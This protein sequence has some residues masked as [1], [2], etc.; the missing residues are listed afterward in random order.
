MT[1]IGQTALGTGN[2]VSKLREALKQID[3]GV[4]LDEVRRDLD[5]I[6]DAAE[7]VEKDVEGLADKFKS[8]ANSASA[9]VMAFGVGA[10]VAAVQ[11]DN[12]VGQIQA[13]L[14]ATREEAEALEQQAR[15]VWK[16]GFGESLEEV[17]EGLIRVKQNM[18][19]IDG[20]EIE[21]VTKNA[22]S[23][24]KAFESDVNEVTRAANNLMVNFGVSAEEAFDLLAYGAQTGLNFSNELFDNVAEYSGLFKTLGFT[25]EEYFQTLEKGSKQGVYNL[26]YLNDVVKEFG[27][28]IKDGS[29]ST[30]DALRYLF[31]SPEFDTF[32]DNLEKGGKKS[33]EFMELVAKF[34]KE[35]SD[36]L[37]ADLQKGGKAAIEAYEYLEYQFG[38]SGLLLQGISDGSLRGQ[39]AMQQV[40]D[41]VFEIDDASV[42]AQMGVAMFG[43]KW[44]DLEE[45]A[46]SALTGID[47][48]LEN[49]E[50]R[51]KELT[52]VQEQ[53]F[54]QQWGAFTRS[55]AASLEPIGKILLNLAEDWMPKVINVVETGANWFA[56]L[57]PVMQGTTVA[58]GGV[59]AALGPL[60]MVGGSLVST[61]TS[62]V[63]LFS[64]GGV[65]AGAFGTAL[66]VLSGPVG[67]A[68]IGIATVGTAA[69]VTSKQL[70]ESSI[71]IQ[72]WSEGV[73]EATATA[74]GS[75][76]EISDSVSQTLT[77]L[78]LTSTRITDE[79]A[80]DLTGRFDSMY[81]QI[82]AAANEKHQKQMNSL[83]DY[84]M[85]SSA[86]SSQEEARILENRQKANE[87]EMAMLE[88][89][90]ERI[91]LIMQKAADENRAL[92][93]REQKVIS[94]INQQMK[95]DAV[96]VLSE[97]EMEQK[98]ILEKMKAEAS[99]VTALQA[100]EV[101]K[102]A[103]SQKE[104]VISEA[105]EQYDKTIAQI[106]R[107]RDETGDITAQQAEKMIAEAKKSRDQ[108]IYYAE[109]MHEK[110]VSEAKAQAGE[111][112][113]QVDWETGEVKSKWEVMKTDVSSKMK[114]IGSG[115]KKD[116]SQAWTDTKTN[117]ENIKK[118]ATDKFKETKEGIT[119]SIN[120]ARDAVNEA[121]Q[122]IKSFFSGLTLELPEIKVPKLPKFTMTGEFSLNPPS[123]PKLGIQWNAKGAIFTKPTVFNSPN[124]GLQG[125]GEAGPEAAIPLNNS[126]L[127]TIGQMIAQ[128]MP[129]GSQAVTVHIE[130]APVVL[131]GQKVAEVTFQS[132]SQ[133]QRSAAN[134]TAITRGV[135][136]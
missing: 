9:N 61:I 128:T 28:R 134:L 104:K 8:V 56:D 79:M 82:A 1:I 86:L 16:A 113:K 5:R 18:H 66:G 107:M 90:N 119:N 54:G 63:A 121:I 44:E 96:R 14:G 133:L 49:V 127:G 68:A 50:G 85:N 89:K 116:W 73:S 99:K 11:F 10:G 30:G 33:Q 42:R 88:A 4:N 105:N 17:S 41:K 118:A 130:P 22:L 132:T 52:A 129:T 95:E 34:G 43:T 37:V 92:T 84:F 19:V 65:A 58:V 136:L 47:G 98:I 117:V 80:A 60:I 6:G 102:N 103:V 24:A 122:K 135:T 101:V 81:N 78:H 55:A 27:I 20:S 109:E 39:E 7:E 38:E 111:H 21:D 71:E 26:D 46:M 94:E 110:I 72:D 25:A 75:F 76:L 3:N 91:A 77:E 35:S 31:R 123:V 93:E 48:N 108:T 97:N 126:V 114:E 36:Q 45:M 12:A 74:V 69:V 106:T 59:T 51:M 13:G 32:M 70:G 29:E 57:P 83:S 2:D 53:T 124:Y 115:I 120:E 64:A 100:A 87:N 62:T 67:W 40:L 112:V 15:N 23:L 131:D 125:F